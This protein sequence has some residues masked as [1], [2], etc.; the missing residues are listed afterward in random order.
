MTDIKTIPCAQCNGTGFANISGEACPL[1]K[2]TGM[3]AAGPAGVGREQY[4]S[5]AINDLMQ[6]IHANNVAKGFTDSM[7]DIHA[8]HM[9]FVTEVAESYDEVRKGKAVGD[10]YY[11]F[12]PD[13]AKPLGVPVELAD[14]V[15]RIFGF[16][17]HHGIDLATAI[18]H[19]MAYNRTR[20]FMHGKKF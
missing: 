8:Q 9:L 11:E 4:F 18:L 16:C 6:D 5:E 2:G 10:M 13:P 20:P 1:C 15:I 17:Q 3:L 12:E 19:K 7:N 14:T